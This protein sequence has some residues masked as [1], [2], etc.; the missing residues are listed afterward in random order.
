VLRSTADFLKEQNICAPTIIIGDQYKA[1][2]LLV[3]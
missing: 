2:P 1:G 3:I